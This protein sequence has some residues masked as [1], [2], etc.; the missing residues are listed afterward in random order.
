[1]LIAEIE[2]AARKDCEV[3]VPDGWHHN[4]WDTIDDGAAL[5]FPQS[6]GPGSCI[7]NCGNCDDDNPPSPYECE[8]LYGDGVETGTDETDGGDETGGG[9]PSTTR[10]GSITW[11]H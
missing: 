1:M 11:P 4:C 10:K 7:G 9:G 8:E 2:K 5:G 3:H 6:D